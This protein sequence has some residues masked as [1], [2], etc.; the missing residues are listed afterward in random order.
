[1]PMNYVPCLRPML[2]C[3][4]FQVIYTSECDDKGCCPCGNDFKTK[5]VSPKPDMDGWE[6]AQI[7]GSLYGKLIDYQSHDRHTGIDHHE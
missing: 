5:C 7:N 6:Y 4:W 1:M 3:E 2:E